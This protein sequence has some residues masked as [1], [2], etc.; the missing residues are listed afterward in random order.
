M[1]QEAH[2]FREEH[3]L[4]EDEQMTA[5]R[6]KQHDEEKTYRDTRTEKKKGK[7]VFVKYRIGRYKSHTPGAAFQARLLDNQEGTNTEPYA[8]GKLSA[9]RFQSR[10][11]GATTLFKLWRYRARKNRPREVG[12]MYTVVDRII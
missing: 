8:S 1:R 7:S 2:D 3:V 5:A 4:A 9:R 11:F 10:P 12:V 6:T